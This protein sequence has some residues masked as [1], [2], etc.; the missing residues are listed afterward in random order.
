MSVG[1]LNECA[2]VGETHYGDRLV[3]FVLLLLL[4]FLF[5]FAF[6]PILVFPKMLESSSSSSLKQ[7]WTEKKD[8]E[9]P[10]VSVSAVVLDS[11]S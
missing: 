9:S 6:I 10:E 5:F 8:S 2:Q 1:L 3:S 7:V 11:T 4:F